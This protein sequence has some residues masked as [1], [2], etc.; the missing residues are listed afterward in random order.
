MVD[1]HADALV[2]LL[3]PP[4]GAMHVVVPLPM[5]EQGTRPGRH[6]LIE[7]RNRVVVL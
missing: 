3:H 1:H 5:H 2:L 7:E 4:Q 6:E